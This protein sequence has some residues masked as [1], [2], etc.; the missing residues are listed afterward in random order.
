MMDD[1]SVVGLVPQVVCGTGEELKQ[2]LERPKVPTVHWDD[3]GGLHEA[4]R[5]ILDLVGALRLE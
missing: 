5:E 1:C 2:G 3:I 4:K